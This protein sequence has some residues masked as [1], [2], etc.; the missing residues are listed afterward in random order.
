MVMVS[1]LMVAQGAH[2]G[3]GHHHA[4]GTMLLYAQ[5]MAMDAVWTQPEYEADM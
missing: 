3:A 1:R 2:V 4:A 5:E